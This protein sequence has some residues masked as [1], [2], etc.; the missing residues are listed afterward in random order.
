MKYR[1]YLTLLFL[2]C[3]QSLSFA[4]GQIVVA[5][6]IW[7]D[8][9]NPDGSGYYT[10][11][12]KAIYEPR[13]IKVVVK[14]V[15]YKR[16]VEMMQSDKADVVLGVYKSENLP[17]S[18]A[19]QPLEMDVV[20]A[21][22]SPAL[23]ATWSGLESLAGKKVGAVLGNDF[24]EFVPVS[25]QYKELS[26]LKS[27]VKMLNHQ[28]ID[29]ILDYEADIQR[30]LQLS[31]EAANFEIKFGVIQNPSFAVFSNSSHGKAMLAIFNEAFIK[32]HESGKLKELLM[33]NTGSLSGYP[34]LK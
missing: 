4:A 8:F 30:E 32:L 7:E 9:S 16:S 18:Y 33:N 5:T 11:I 1:R 27:L 13:G 15:P 20:D 26:K 3:L 2:S 24:N 17:G 14:Y 34:V 22:I 25:I 23:A 21:A 12:L 19:D 29:A 10:D 31:G 28:R 6:D